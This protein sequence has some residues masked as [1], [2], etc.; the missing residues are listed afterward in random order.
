LSDDWPVRAPDRWARISARAGAF[1]ALDV[2]LRNVIDLSLDGDQSFLARC[3]FQQ[4]CEHNV[5][6][7]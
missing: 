5:T 6:L 2:F 3:D 4:E 7:K 1:K